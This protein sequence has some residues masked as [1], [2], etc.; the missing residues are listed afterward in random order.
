MKSAVPI[1]ALLLAVTGCGQSEN[2]STPFAPYIL[3]PAVEGRPGA[4]YFDLQVRADQAALRSVTSSQIGR[5]E[6]HETMSSGTMSRM[7]PIDRVPIVADERLIFAPGG[8]HLMLF[9]L[10]PALRSGSQI[11]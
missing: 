6:M 7:R 11:S 1:L 10:D 2:R 5:I 8:R 9:D 4:G 3:L